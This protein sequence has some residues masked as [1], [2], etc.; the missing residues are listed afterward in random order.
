MA[1]APTGNFTISISADVEFQ[2]GEK[3]KKSA[4]DELKSI[5]WAHTTELKTSCE[6]SFKGGVSYRFH[7]CFISTKR[8]T[9]ATHRKTLKQAF[10]EIVTKH[11]PHICFEP[12]ELKSY[13]IESNGTYLCGRSPKESP[14]VLVPKNPRDFKSINQEMASKLAEL[15]QLWHTSYELDDDLLPH[16]YTPHITIVNRKALTVLEKQTGTTKDVLIE[17]LNSTGPWGTLTL[18][19]HKYKI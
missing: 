4:Q 12:S 7:V 2:L 19:K 10:V 13:V 1:S 15:N 17:K 16:H 9:D 18:K 11:I 3:T 8:I 6:K 14:I 5:F